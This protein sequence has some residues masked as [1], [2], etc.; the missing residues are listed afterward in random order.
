ML[1]FKTESKSVEE[2]KRESGPPA[3]INTTAVLCQFF[4]FNGKL[5]SMRSEAENIAVVDDDSLAN[6]TAMAN[7]ARKIKGKISKR[8]K[9]VVSP[10]VDAKRSVEGRIRDL[11]IEPFSNLEK[12]LDGKINPYLLKKE[13]ERKVAEDAAAAK[14]R[15]VQAQA[16]RKVVDLRARTGGG[17]PAHAPLEPPPSPA[18]PVLVPE[19]VE[20]Q[21]KVQTDSGS[22]TV[23]TVP[24]PY[25]LDLSKAV[26]NP[27]FIKAN[28]KLLT[29]R[30]LVFSRNMIKTGNRNIPGVEVRDE[31]KITRRIK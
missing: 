30:V 13:Q 5:A 17:S 31:P 10:W 12:T 18:P 2:T 27:A 1:D 8:L 20:D 26:S 19:I 4:K 23:D 9:E 29:E 15:E 6:A 21:T 25:V 7:Q 24:V 3:A 28:S 22:A 11:L 16:D 14:I